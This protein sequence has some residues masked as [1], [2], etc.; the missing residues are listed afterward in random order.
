M[1]HSTEICYLKQEI[2]RLEETLDSR[3]REAARY[4]ETIDK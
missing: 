2:F 4:E 1:R 3:R